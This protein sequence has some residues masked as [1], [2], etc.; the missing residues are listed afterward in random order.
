MRTSFQLLVLSVLSSPP[1]L[2][3]KLLSLPETS[4]PCALVVPTDPSPHTWL[5]PL[6]SVRSLHCGACGPTHL[7]VVLIMAAISFICGLSFSFTKLQEIFI[8]LCLIC[9]TS[10]FPAPRW[11]WMWMNKW[12]NKKAKVQVKQ[13]KQ[14]EV[15][16]GLP[17]VQ[18][19]HEQAQKQGGRIS[20]LAVG[21]HWIPWAKVTY[22]GVSF[23][24]AGLAWSFLK[25][26]FSASGGDWSV[27]WIT[28]SKF[29]ITQDQ[30]SSYWASLISPMLQPLGGAQG[31]PLLSA[32]W[33][34]Q[35][36]GS[37]WEE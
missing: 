24:S 8:L 11:P 1:C 2:C 25:S 17:G 27:C 14:L 3:R 30:W 5:S 26:Q 21:L 31:F 18:S 33:P 19:W 15:R 12:M 16:G 28:R 36:G 13:K 37:Q 7:F 6:S 4:F 32:H 34:K 23:R 20:V 9:L 29:R 35:K 22:V 10:V